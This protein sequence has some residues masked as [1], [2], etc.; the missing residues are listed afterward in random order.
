MGKKKDKEQR[1][2]RTIFPILIEVETWKDLIEALTVGIGLIFH[3]PLKKK[4][5]FYYFYATMG[6]SI[7]MLF[8]IVSKEQHK[9]YVGI[10]K[11]KV[12]EADYPSN[13]TPLAIINIKDDP[14]ALASLDGI[15]VI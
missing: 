14:I 5:H 1:W 12:V 8:G 3:I 10:V 2:Y 13:D 11:D 7:M 4:K 6:D 15:D 9:K